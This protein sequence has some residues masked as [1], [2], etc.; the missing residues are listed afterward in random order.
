M[1]AEGYLL[2]GIHHVLAHP[3]HIT[4]CLE[5][6]VGCDEREQILCGRGVAVGYFLHGGVPSHCYAGLACHLR[7]VCECEAFDVGLP[8]VGNVGEAD[9]SGVDA[10]EEH[11]AG[12]SH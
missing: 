6:V 11:V 12:E 9:A 1:A 5:L 3:L 8:D 2:E 4:A 7:G 10:E